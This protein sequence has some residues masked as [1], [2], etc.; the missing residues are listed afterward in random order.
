[1]DDHRGSQHIEHDNQ[2][3]GTFIS[4]GLSEL[5]TRIMRQIIDNNLSAH[6]H[7]LIALLRRIRSKL[8]D[9]HH[10]YIIADDDSIDEDSINVLF[11]ELEDELQL[12]KGSTANNPSSPNV[13]AVKYCIAGRRHPHVVLD[14]HTRNYAPVIAAVEAS[15]GDRTI[16]D[17]GRSSGD[18]GL[19]PSWATMGHS[20]S[21]SGEKASIAGKDPSTVNVVEGPA[22][23]A[24]PPNVTV[25]TTGLAR[26]LFHHDNG[27]NFTWHVNPDDILFNGTD[28]GSAYPVMAS[29]VKGY[30]PDYFISETPWFGIQGVATANGMNLYY[31]VDTVS[32]SKDLVLSVEH[33]I[34]MN[35]V[36]GGW[37]FDV[38]FK[39]V[40]GGRNAP[41][42]YVRH[43]AS[44]TL[45]L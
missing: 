4:D 16:A 45:L 25:E 11:N 21:C 26:M 39:V 28:Y 6:E 1:M 38:A 9:N 41:F 29:R 14:E 12:P 19:M 3:I 35:R 27:M 30:L 15:R 44:G 33:K 23:S 40:R 10:V 36:E 34:S 5:K 22:D 20:S 8:K 17:R 18:Q 24:D 42:S 13:Q 31:S 2:W 37:D 32:R 43:F 7:S